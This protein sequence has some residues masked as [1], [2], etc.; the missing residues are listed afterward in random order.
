MLKHSLANYPKEFL[1]Y[2]I[3]PT[4]ICI[5]FSEVSTK[6]RFKEGGQY[7]KLLDTSKALPI[8]TTSTE[9]DILAVGC[10]MPVLENLQ[11]SLIKAYKEYKIRHEKEYK[12]KYNKE[13]KDFLLKIKM[14]IEDALKE[15]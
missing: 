13:F 7:I 8:K 1:G 3:S 15:S 6:L 4:K 14:E 12:E 11:M 5:Q 2:V 9:I 10:Q